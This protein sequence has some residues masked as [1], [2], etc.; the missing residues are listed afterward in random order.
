MYNYIS[1]KN[2]KRR[3]CFV[4]LLTRV[5]DKLFNIQL[6]EKLHKGRTKIGLHIPHF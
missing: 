5:K 3:I 4:L 6:L 1:K 2:E